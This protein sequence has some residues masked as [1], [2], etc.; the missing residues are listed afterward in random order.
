[1]A[2][3]RQVEEKEVPCPR[4]HGKGEIP[5]YRHVE[6]GICFKCRGRKT[7][8]QWVPVKADPQ[9]DAPPSAHG[10]MGDLPL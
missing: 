1:M 6:M 2:H 8:T 9:P 3:Q 7:I 4:C 10:Y 5:V